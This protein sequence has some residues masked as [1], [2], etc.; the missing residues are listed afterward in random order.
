[1]LDATRAI[2]YGFVSATHM[3]RVDPSRYPDENPLIL[4]SGIPAIAEFASDYE[5]GTEP[6]PSSTSS[7]S[8]TKTTSDEQRETPVGII[9]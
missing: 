6:T 7:P 2:G 3:L 9:L 4:D 8:P 5:A 1:M